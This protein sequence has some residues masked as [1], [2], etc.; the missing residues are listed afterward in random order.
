MS[1]FRCV[2]NVVAADVLSLSSLRVCVR[3]MF[4]SSVTGTHSLDTS[5]SALCWGTGAIEI[6][7]MDCLLENDGNKGIL[8]CNVKVKYCKDKN[9][10][11]IYTEVVSK[12]LSSCLFLL[13]LCWSGTL[14]READENFFCL[15]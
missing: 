14:A 2:A 13:N 9:E 4:L 5:F 11:H 7:D 12:Y 1:A 3:Y 15:R 8:I 10:S 6:R